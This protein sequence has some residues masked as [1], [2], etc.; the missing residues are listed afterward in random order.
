MS[1][2]EIRPEFSAT[3]SKESVESGEVVRTCGEPPLLQP[4]SHGS[5]EW[6]F[7]RTWRELEGSRRTVMF[8]SPVSQGGERWDR[9]DTLRREGA[10]E[11]HRYAVC[12]NREFFFHRSSSQA[13]QGNFYITRGAVVSSVG[14]LDR[15]S[16]CVVEFPVRK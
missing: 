9:F 15:G 3:S 7:L 11:R 5:L 16:K 4:S 13:R 8:M 12:E 6:S 2:M 1:P 14:R 10:R